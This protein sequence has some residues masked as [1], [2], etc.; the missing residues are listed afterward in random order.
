MK[1]IEIR[2]IS[3]P[4]QSRKNEDYIICQKL[5]DNIHIAILADGMGGLSHGAEAAETVS[6]SILATISETIGDCS[7]ED[8]I[9]M[10]FT[11][12]DSAI[13]NKC[14]ELKCK[15]GAAVTVALIIDDDMY[16]AW[17]G[18]VRLYVVANNNVLLLTT[19]HI[20]AGTGGTFLTRCI[21]GKGFREEI[22]I[23][24][25]E[26]TQVDRIYL[27]SDGFYQ[28]VNMNAFRNFDPP[29]SFNKVIE[30][31]ASFVELRLPQ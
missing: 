10:A 16:Y 17:Q 5:A 11:V 6:R 31:D 12:A 22:E 27:C 20:V 24:R 21:N 28:Q 9:P 3:V 29:F 23:K 18:N 7:P 4:G 2:A 8:I 30:D 14:K 26:L 15:M 13:L 19:D 25:A 1:T